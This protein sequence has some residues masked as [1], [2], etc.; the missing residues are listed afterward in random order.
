[1]N[2]EAKGEQG[3]GDN[4]KAVDEAESET[5]GDADHTGSG[6]LEASCGSAP[7]RVWVW[8]LCLKGAM[9][10]PSVFIDMIVSFFNQINYRLSILRFGNARRVLSRSRTR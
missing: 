9:R 5:I 8:V 10:R 2:E 4:D 3:K 6:H 7:R 1:M